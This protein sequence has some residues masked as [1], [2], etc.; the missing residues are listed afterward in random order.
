MSTL[1][2][3]A[4]GAEETGWLSREQAATQLGISLRTLDRARKDWP[5]EVQRIS[6]RLGQVGRILIDPAY[7]RQLEQG[8][9]LDEVPE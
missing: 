7:V 3:P 5:D 4:N 6:T 1:I 2:A 9:I 8:P